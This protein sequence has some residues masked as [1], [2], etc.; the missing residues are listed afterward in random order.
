MHLLVH[1]E[2]GQRVY[3][4]GGN[5][6]DKVK[7]PPTTTLL[8]FFDLCKVDRFFARTL[9]YMVQFLCITCRKATSFEEQLDMAVFNKT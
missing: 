8:G 4:H 6:E 2:N 9:V 5:V 7:N 3:F 1:L